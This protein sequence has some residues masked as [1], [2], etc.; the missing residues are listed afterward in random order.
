M[1][2]VEDLADEV[3]IGHICNHAQLSAAQRAECDRR[4]RSRSDR[5]KMRFNRYA[6]V[7]GAVGGSLQ[8]L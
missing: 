1:D 7:S 5:T 3:G 8:W 2:V 6:Q 4:C